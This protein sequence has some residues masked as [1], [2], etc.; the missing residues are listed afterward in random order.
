MSRRQILGLLVAVAA[1]AGVALAI[2]AGVSAA[3]PRTI[4]TARVQRG[5]V[6]VTVFTNGELRASRR[7]Q[8]IVPPTGGQLQ[9]VTLADPG[10]A[11]KN[12]DVVVEFD[13]AEQEFSLEQA[14]FDLRLA[15]QEM[16]K[17]DA[18]AAVQVAADEVALLQARYDVRRAELET[19]AN[20][21]VSEITAKQNVLLLE[22][23][24]Q[25]L[26]QVESDVVAH[27]TTG[28]ASAAGLREKRT[29]ARL[30]VQVAERNIASLTVRAPFDG[31]V[32][33]RTNFMAFGGIGFPG[34]PEYRVGD[35]TL[36]G[37][38]IADVFDTS[39]V[40]VTAKLSERDR[41]NVAA[42]QA[43]EVAVDAAPAAKLRGTVRAVSGVASRSIFDT[44]TRQFDIAF[45]VGG[46]VLARPGV[47]A[48]ISIA[49]PTYPDVLYVPR[50][51]V[52]DAAGKPTLY[53]RT[54]DGFDAREVR[55]R[56]WT[57]SLAVIENVDQSAE[58]ALVDPTAASGVRQRLQAPGAPQRAGR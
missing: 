18:E 50:T 43:V 2:A 30:A 45:N 17:A 11:V 8:L 56:A 47:T 28:L 58:V 23:A 37:Q 20:E 26:A 32:T 22:E 38:T 48:A 14:R 31:Y 54:A 27:R 7:T 19:Q 36:A 10:A 55:V 13:P 5:R 9:I 53:V 49:G 40:E 34:M 24:R 51:A 42:G 6:D 3:D 16:V 44:G 4:P 46:Q 21:L 1:I 57:D 41:A 33:I 35:S 12:G 52:F 29:K 25:R 39:Q 15:E